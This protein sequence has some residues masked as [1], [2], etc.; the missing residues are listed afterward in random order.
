[1]NNSVRCASTAVAES[2]ARLARDTGKDGWLQLIHLH[3]ATSKQ[4]SV[5]IFCKTNAPLDVIFSNYE[6][7]SR[8][9]LAASENRINKRK[10]ITQQCSSTHVIEFLFVV[11]NRI[12]W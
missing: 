11:D 10:H 2:V 1:M 12:F 5:C 4:T 8:S 6:F 3:A 7:L 9:T